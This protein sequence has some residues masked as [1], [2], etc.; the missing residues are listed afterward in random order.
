LPIEIN[1]TAHVV[2]MGNY[3]PCTTSAAGSLAQHGPVLLIMVGDGRWCVGGVGGDFS[4]TDQPI[5]TQNDSN[6]VHSRK[7]DT[8][9]VKTASFHTH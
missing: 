1:N 9:A 4:H 5:L 6:D 8:F 3:T 7:D 2:S